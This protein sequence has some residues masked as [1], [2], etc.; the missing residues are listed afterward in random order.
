M[1]SFQIL[2]S[3]S[4]SKPYW[5]NFVRHIC[6]VVFT[7]SRVTKPSFSIP[8]T[9]PTF[10]IFTIFR[11]LLL[12]HLFVGW[13]FIAKNQL[14]KTMFSIVLQC[15][16]KGLQQKNSWAH[17]FETLTFQIHLFGTKKKFSYLFGNPIYRGASTYQYVIIILLCD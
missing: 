5:Y 7:D 11:F 2:L 13:H 15:Q 4:F 16:W 1:V 17:F 6:K 8:L 12:K 14:I 9:I 10:T 3:E